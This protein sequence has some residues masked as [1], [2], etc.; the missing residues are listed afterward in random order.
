[1]K[2]TQNSKLNYTGTILVLC[3]S[4]WHHLPIRLIETLRHFRAVKAN[5]DKLKKARMIAG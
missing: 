5:V 4:C 1:M 3:E 2:V